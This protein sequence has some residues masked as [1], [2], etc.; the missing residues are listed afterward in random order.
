[1]LWKMASLMM[2][3]NISRSIALSMREGDHRALR[4]LSLPV[5]PSIPSEHQLDSGVYL[6]GL[7]RNVGETINTGQT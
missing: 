5:S 1:M 6:E 4:D 2:R 3:R 7:R